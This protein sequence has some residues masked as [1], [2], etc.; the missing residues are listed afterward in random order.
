MDLAIKTNSTHILF[1]ELGENYAEISKFK[2]NNIKVLFQKYLHPE[3]KQFNT[4]KFISKLSAIDLLFNCGI[5]S[6]KFLLSNN[7]TKENYLKF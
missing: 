3:Y 4:K 6:K 1:G 2:N 7:L 5:D